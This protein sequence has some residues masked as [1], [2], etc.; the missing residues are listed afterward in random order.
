MTIHRLAILMFF[1]AV[2][3]SLIRGAS[4]ARLYLDIYPRTAKCYLEGDL[5]DHQLPVLVQQGSYD[6]RVTHPGFPNHVRKVRVDA[7]SMLVRIYPIK[8]NYSPPD[9]RLRIKGRKAGFEDRGSRVL[10]DSPGTY[11]LK[12]SRGLR[13]KSASVE[14]KAPY[15]EHEIGIVIRTRKEEK[16]WGHAFS[17]EL[18]FYPNSGNIGVNLS[19]LG[20]KTEGKFGKTKFHFGIAVLDGSIGIPTSYSLCLFAGETGLNYFSPD[21]YNRISLH[22]KLNVMGMDWGAAD[23]Y[24]GDFVYAPPDDEYNLHGYEVYKYKDAYCI[25]I[26]SK[27]AAHR[28][29]LSYSRYLSDY[30]D[31]TFSLGVYIAA[32]YT[33]FRASHWDVPESDRDYLSKREIM[34]LSPF[35]EG[36]QP[37]LSISLRPLTFNGKRGSK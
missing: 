31:I 10:L 5:V 25:L 35:P 14:V 13:F 33:W 8:I 24:Q 20:A 37:Y 27:W 4:I 23:K 3:P 22:Y 28:F 12:L 9:A 18:A 17:P 2:F 11:D 16:A 34:K 30:M 36:T 6:L 32:Q 1:L 29:Y 21:G 26:P 7:D 19:P 15:S